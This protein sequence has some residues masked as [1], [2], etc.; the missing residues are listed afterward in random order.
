[1]VYGISNGGLYGEWCVNGKSELVNG[2]PEVNG[3]W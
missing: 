3:I 2:G 1:M